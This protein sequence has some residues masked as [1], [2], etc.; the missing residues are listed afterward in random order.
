[1]KIAAL[2]LLAGLA[3]YGFQRMRSP[4]YDSGRVNAPYEREMQN[5]AD[6]P[7]DA[8]EKAEYSFARL[9]YRGYGGFRRSSWGTDSNKAERQFVQGVRRLTRVHTRSVEQIVDVDSDD[10]YNWPWLYAVEVGYWQLDQSQ[11]KRLRDYLDR[12]GFLMVDD[13]HGNTEWSIFMES[14][15]KVFPD[16]GVEDLADSNEIFHTL[17]D[18]QHRIQI[19][20]ARA[21]ADGVTYEQPEDGGKEPHWRAVFD[22]RNRVVVAICHDMDLGDAWEHADDPL[23]PENMTGL[24]YRIAI[25]YVVYDM[26]H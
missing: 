1:M 18:L 12:G 4:Y 6:D 17:Y 11:A 9:R 3:L 23:Y 15:S 14:L 25:N 19:P 7:P 5:P 10:I 22:D 21:W 26:T 8:L 2:L 16:R 24:A 20:G 13:F